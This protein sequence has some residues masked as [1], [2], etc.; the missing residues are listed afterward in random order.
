MVNANHDWLLFNPHNLKSNSSYYQQQILIARFYGF[1]RNLHRI[2]VDRID[3]ERESYRKFQ[4]SL[5][6]AQA[7]CHNEAINKLN[8][9]MMMIS[10]I[11]STDMRGKFDQL[12]RSTEVMDSLLTS[13]AYSVPRKQEA[14]AVSAV[15]TFDKLFNNHESDQIRNTKEMPFLHWQTVYPTNLLS[16]W[17][18]RK[19]VG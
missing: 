7:S 1:L 19:S 11:L 3:S 10:S 4:K 15:L 18:D 12:L 8:M 16:S 17:G 2:V 14:Y 6:S 9:Q 13:E 5:K